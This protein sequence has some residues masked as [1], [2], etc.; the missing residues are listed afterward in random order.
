[1]FKGRAL[2]R[3]HGE[4][5]NSSEIICRRGKRLSL[6]VTESEPNEAFARTLATYIT[7]FQTEPKCRQAPHELV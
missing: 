5:E 2:S 6:P 1:M 3:G 4:E 7:F